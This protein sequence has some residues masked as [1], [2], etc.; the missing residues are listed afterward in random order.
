MAAQRLGGFLA[1]ALLGMTINVGVTSTLALA[2]GAWRAAAKAA[3]LGVG[4]WVVDVTAKAAG[5][6][7]A[8]VLNFWLNTTIVFREPARP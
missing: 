5:I 4:P 2:L 8:F 3:E 6:G 7:A 1:V